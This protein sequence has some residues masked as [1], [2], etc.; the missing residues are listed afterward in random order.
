MTSSTARRSPESP[1][2]G[3]P[4]LPLV[5]AAGSPASPAS[6]P[7]RPREE[8]LHDHVRDPRDC[9]VSQQGSDGVFIGNVLRRRQRHH[10]RMPAQE[11]GHQG[12]P[13]IHR[14]PVAAIGEII[15]R[16][17][18]TQSDQNITRVIT[19]PA[20][21]SVG[22]PPMS[23]AV[24]MSHSSVR[25]GEDRALRTLLAAQFQWRHRSTAPR[26]Q[27]RRRTEPEDE[28]G[29]PPRSHP[30]PLADSPIRNASMG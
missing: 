17:I 4:S 18:H 26:R 22:C 10:P 27:I 2:R 12:T 30:R 15:A 14:P 11:I 28:P 25:S 5:S 13:G 1:A 16:K 29:D 7:R 20:I 24:K 9:A 23:G 6:L 21:N 19:A 3:R 8:P